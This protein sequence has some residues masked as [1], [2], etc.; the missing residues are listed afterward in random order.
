[1]DYFST[2]DSDFNKVSDQRR[3]NLYL[4]GRELLLKLADESTGTRYLGPLESTAMFLG[5]KQ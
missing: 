3:K 1:V 2:F 4:K 5:L